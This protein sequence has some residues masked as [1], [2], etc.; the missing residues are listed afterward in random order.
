[1]AAI[2]VHVLRHDHWVEV[3]SAHVRLADVASQ[4]MAS[5]SR[6]K[7]TLGQIER[8]TF[9]L[10]EENVMQKLRSSCVSLFLS[11]V[12]LGASSYAQAIPYT[13]IVIFGDSLSDTGNFFAATGTP[14]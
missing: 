1:M 2:G 6:L 13:D 7:K 5:A 14:P 12:L 4:T 8:P 11:A 9:Q 10:N 3:L